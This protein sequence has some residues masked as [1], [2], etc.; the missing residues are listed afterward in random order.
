MPFYSFFEEIFIILQAQHNNIIV[1][2][3]FIAL[4]VLVIAMRV[5][6]FVN[7]R[8][9]NLWLARELHPTRAL[10]TLADTGDI[11]SPL[12]RRIVADYIAAAEKN[13]PRV[14][15]DTIVN[16][17][18]LNLSLAGWRY[19]GISA[20]I[21]KLDNG[22]IFLGLVLALIFPEYA[23]VY[24]LLAISGFALLKCTAAFFDFDTARLLLTD[25]I[26]LYVE[27][28][29]GQF[30]AGHTAG[31]ISQ[32]KEEMAEAIDRQSVLLRG[33]VE[34]LS[35]DLAPA[36]TNLQCLTDL[37][38][39]LENMQQSNDR[40]V[41]HHEA[42][43]AQA[44]LIK[45]IQTALE[46]SLA[47]YET[48]LQNLVQTMGSGL[49]TFIEMHGQTA[50]SGLTEALQTHVARA[51]EGNQEAISAMTALVDQLTAQNRDIS[52]HLRTLHERID[53]R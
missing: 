8:G 51:A 32:F 48:T 10:K 1:M 33:A 44:A 29:V 18:I 20:W 28:E 49:G 38:K 35:A 17:H 34:K 27:R 46:S 52:A 43:M 9:Q 22:L 13:A 14:P 37:P 3:V 21:E 40:Y 53:S 31:A 24:G 23:I 12:L 5:A 11:R 45:E 30:F 39:A 6:V 50:A 7:Y 42:F 36:L 2:A 41:V 19:S 25:D 4:H 15:L 16:K 47:S 26:H